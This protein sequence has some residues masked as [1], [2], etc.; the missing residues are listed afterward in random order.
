MVKPDSV[1]DFLLSP[2]TF[3]HFGIHRAARLC[4]RQCQGPRTCS[5]SW[6]LWKQT[7]KWRWE[8]TL[9]TRSPVLGPSSHTVWGHL[10]TQ[11]L[12]EC[13]RCP[14]GAFLPLCQL[15]GIQLSPQF[16]NQVVLWLLMR[17]W[18]GRWEMAGAILLAEDHH[19]KTIFLAGTNQ[20]QNQ[21]KNKTEPRGRQD[22]WEL[23][24]KSQWI[25]FK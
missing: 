13:L 2:A 23:T 4:V 3:R 9:A 22:A 19:W 16:Y 15:E 14:F 25:D 17:D 7:L 12:L 1:T 20:T 18:T 10:S 8:F 24:R 21:L 5:R 6:V 11:P